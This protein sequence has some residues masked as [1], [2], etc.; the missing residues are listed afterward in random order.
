MARGFVELVCQ[1]IL[2]CP[3]PVKVGVAWSRTGRTRLFGEFLMRGLEQ[4]VAMGKSIAVKGELKE[5]LR[6][7]WR[8]DMLPLDPRVGTLKARIDERGMTPAIQAEVRSYFV[9]WINECENSR[10]VAGRLSGL[11]RDAMAERSGRE[12]RLSIY[13]S[14]EFAIAAF[15]RHVLHVPEDEM[16]PDLAEFVR[17]EGGHYYYRGWR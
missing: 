10:R 17:A 5:D 12:W 14:H 6:P 8:D 1:E 11:L 7:E 2:L 15:N 4:L 16:F 9:R 3:R 13:F